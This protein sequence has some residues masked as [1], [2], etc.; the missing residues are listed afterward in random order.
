MVHQ[1]EKRELVGVD[2]FMQS[3]DRNAENLANRIQNASSNLL[4]QLQMI[5][6]RGTKV[7]PNGF[8]ETFCTDHWR[9][10]FKPENVGTEIS[11]DHVVKLMQELNSAGLD[12]IK[13]E[14]LYYFDGKPGFT[15]AQ[16]Q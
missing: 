3:T 7:W 5:T 8:P 11:Y 6:N 4:L 13:T 14:N 10:R 1:P 12:I 16:G 9:C 2:I 15:A